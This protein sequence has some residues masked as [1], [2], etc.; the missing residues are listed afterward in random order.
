MNP[1]HYHLE[2]YENTGGSMP[3]LE[4]LKKLAG[5]SGLFGS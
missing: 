5:V 2:F 3:V 4:W 1:E